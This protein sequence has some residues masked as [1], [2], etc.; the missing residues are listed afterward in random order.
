MAFIDGIQSPTET[1]L[2]KFI[3]EFVIHHSLIQIR[4]DSTV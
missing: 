3:G 1:V 4:P 2:Y